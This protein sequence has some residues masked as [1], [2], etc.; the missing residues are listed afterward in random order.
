[1]G[2]L[3]LAAAGILAWRNSRIIAEQRK[4]KGAIPAVS[5]YTVQV[6][7]QSETET[8]VNVT[9]LIE[10]AY[11]ELQGTVR[12][13]LCRMNGT[14]SELKLEH[15]V[16]I[17]EHTCSEYADQGS[18]IEVLTYSEAVRNEEEGK[19]LDRLGQR[20]QRSQS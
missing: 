20:L 11:Q 19:A 9:P 18:V 14:M 15:A 2:V 7:R 6:T 4:T 17:M 1:M 16:Q 5:S 8:S 3:I 12:V 13:S 10:A